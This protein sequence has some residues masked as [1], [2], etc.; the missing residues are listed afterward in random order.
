MIWSPLQRLREIREKEAAERKVREA[1]AAITVPTGPFPEP[2]FELINI[3]DDLP[4][5][6]ERKWSNRSTSQIKEIIVHQAAMK[7]TTAQ[8]VNAYHITPSQDENG[9]GRVDSWERNHLS[10][11]GAPQYCL[12]YRD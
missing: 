11:K 8:E 10:D 12:P 7:D 4:W 1:V 2:E 9:D 3:I 5:H 6:P